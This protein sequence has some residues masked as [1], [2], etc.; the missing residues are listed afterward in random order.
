MRENEWQ[1]KASDDNE[2]SDEAAE[3][4]G[5]RALAIVGGEV[6]ST[7]MGE[8]R[9]GKR[10]DHEGQCYFHAQ[11]SSSYYRSGWE[12]EGLQRERER[13]EYKRTDDERQ[14]VWPKSAGEDDHQES[15]CEDEGKQ[16]H[17]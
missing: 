4:D 17:G 7:A 3:V 1:W 6:L 10:S 8:E 16:D 12:G 2:G 13:G 9:I 11:F 15:Y 14:P 5:S